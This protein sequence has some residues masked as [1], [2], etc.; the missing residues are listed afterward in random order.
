MSVAPLAAV[1]LGA[2]VHNGQYTFYNA[3]KI[4]SVDMNKLR[5]Q[6]LIGFL[7][8]LL[9]GTGALHKKS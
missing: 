9:L 4:I 6:L 7:V 1:W 8:F 2:I 5:H 3:N